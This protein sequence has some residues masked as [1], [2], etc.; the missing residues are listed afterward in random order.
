MDAG[1]GVRFLDQAVCLLEATL[2]RKGLTRAQRR[3]YGQMLKEAKRQQAQEVARVWR[4]WPG[5]TPVSM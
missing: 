3:K 2:R 4:E 5:D 1:R